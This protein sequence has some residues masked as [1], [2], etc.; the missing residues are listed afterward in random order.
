MNVHTHHSTKTFF[1]LNTSSFTHIPS[2]GKHLR[3]ALNLH[4]ATSVEPP[5]P[6]KLVE[7]CPDADVVTSRQ[8]ITNLIK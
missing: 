2:K 8:D 6:T 7:T 4:L 5:T 1:V 3:I